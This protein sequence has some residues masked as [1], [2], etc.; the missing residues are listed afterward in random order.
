SA[1]WAGPPRQ[2]TGWPARRSRQKVVGVGPLAG[3]IEEAGGRCPALRS[4]AGVVDGNTEPSAF[5]RSVT[6]PRRI[7]GARV[8]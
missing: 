5:A 6:E 8:V 2:A 4:L 3:A 1:E 7:V